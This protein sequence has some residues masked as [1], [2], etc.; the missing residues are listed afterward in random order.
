MERVH[1]QEANEDSPP[2]KQGFTCLPKEME[3]IEQFATQGI[4]VV[5]QEETPA[6]LRACNAELEKFSGTRHAMDPFPKVAWTW[7]V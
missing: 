5:S 2:C 7:G 4:N 6:S 3:A 1:A